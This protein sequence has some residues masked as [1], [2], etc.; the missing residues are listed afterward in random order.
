[1]DTFP[2]PQRFWHPS[3][4]Q[5]IFSRTLSGGLRFAVTSGYHL[6]GLRLASFLTSSRDQP[7]GF[8]DSARHSQRVSDT[9]P[10]SHLKDGYGP[11][12]V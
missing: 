1:M 4:V 3:G 5:Y 11:T 9:L 10:S 2:E 12:H 8:P 6:A 7:A